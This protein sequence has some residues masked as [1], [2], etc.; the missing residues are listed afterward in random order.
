MTSFS[1][2][3]LLDRSGSMSLH[4]VETLQALNGYITEMA[5][6]RPDAIVTLVA[7][8]EP[9][10][11]GGAMTANPFTG[12][13]TLDSK[14]GYHVLRHKVPANVF[15]P[16]EVNE[17]LPRGGTPLLDALGRITNEMLQ[18]NPE[19]AV[20]VVLTDGHENASKHWQKERIQGRLNELKVKGWEV[21]FLG[22]DFDAVSQAGGLGVVMDKALNMTSGHYGA[23]VA[24][25]AS[26]TVGYAAAGTPMNFSEAD[27]KRARGD[28]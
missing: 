26:S 23:A 27:R 17:C 5:V 15:P 22:A 3:I 16:L 6:A 10:P 19:R 12:Q 28:K 20:L 13:Q 18:A 21:L 11:A 2:N 4:W 25:M 8:D 14:P 24:A 1:I 7:F 9:G